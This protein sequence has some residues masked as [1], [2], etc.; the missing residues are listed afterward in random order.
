MRVAAR[1]ASIALACAGLVLCAAT[2]A[3][4]VLTAEVLRLGRV[5]AGTAPLQNISER[6]LR[7]AGRRAGVGFE[8]V[9]VPLP[10]AIE[11]ANDGD[12]DGDT[13]RI[14]DVLAQYPNLLKIPTPINRIDVAMY[15]AT[16]A[17][18][19]MTRDE[20]TTLRIGYA[21]GVFVLDKYA[22]SP[23]MMQAQRTTDT[24]EMLHNGRVDAAMASYVN[25]QH[26]LIVGAVNDIH[27]WPHVW[28]SEPLYL[29]LNKRHER[30]VAPLDAALQRMARE[31]LIA[32]YYNEELRRLGIARLPD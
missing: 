6:V 9:P 14:A 13:H 31:G 28:A 2:H 21:R 32:A 3:Q 22:R 27:L 16:P 1:S 4:Q 23:G 24:V 12:L 20:I 11:S 30:W 18:R 8:F 15:G 7:E 29:V 5:D 26:R 25:T 17:I 19:A 10:R